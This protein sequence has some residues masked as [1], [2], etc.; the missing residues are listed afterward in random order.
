MK[1]PF[2]NWGM[3][4]V[5]VV[6]DPDKYPPSI[7]KTLDGRMRRLFLQN[8]RL[9]E[10]VPDTEPIYVKS[11]FYVFGVL[12]LTSFIILIV[13]GIILAIFG[14]EWWLK[15]Q[16]GAF[17][18]AMHYWSVEAFFLS[19]LSHFLAVFFTGAFRGKRWLTWMLGVLAFVT[20]IVTAFT[21]YASIQDFEAQWITT[22]GKDAINSTGAGSIFNLLN[23]G[24][25]TTMHVAVFPLIVAAIVGV[26]LLWVR[27]H[28]IAPPYDIREDH[29]APLVKE[30]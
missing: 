29:L 2:E 7:R 6:D 22:Q 1:N 12:T 18:D 21:G 20:S 15:T 24:Q 23:T 16:V 14:P 27:K 13:T 17:V 26:H 9:Q 8:W 10:L 30:V 5:V 4:K 11:W 28:G 19:M 25:M 3:K